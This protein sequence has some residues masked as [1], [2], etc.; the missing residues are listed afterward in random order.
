M[1]DDA[2]AA[3]LARD[4]AH[5]RRALATDASFLVQAPAGSGKTELLIQRYLALLAGVEAPQRVVAMT[6]TRKAASEMRERI[7]TA[8]QMARDGA[9]VTMPHEATTRQL[10]SAV[11]AQADRLGWSLLDHPAQLAIYT[12]DALCATLASQ[13]PIMSRLGPSVRVVERPQALYTLAARAT[14]AAAEAQD[15]HWGRLLATLDNDAA[16]VVDLV[17]SMLA[18]REQ[19]LAHLVDQ[20]PP[21]LRTELESALQAEIEAE[22]GAARARAPA[23]LMVRIA[24]CAQRAADELMAED[25]DAALAAALAQCAAHGGLPPA[26]HAALGHWCAVANWLLT[27]DGAP[28]QRHTRREGVRPPSAGGGTQRDEA[29]AMLAALASAP[30]FVVALDLV[31]TLPPVTI[32]DATWDT[33]LALLHILPRAVAQFRLVCARQGAT[34]FTELALAAVAAL[35]AVDAPSELLLRVDLAIEHLLIDEFQDTSKLQFDLIDLLTAG[36]T[37]GDGRTLFAVGDPMQSIYRFR[38]AEVRLFLQAIDEGRIGSVAVEFLDLARNFRSQGA[39]VGWVNRVF[40]AILGARNEPWRGAVAFAAAAVPDDATPALPPTLDVATSRE[41]EAACTV[42]RVREALAEGSSDI[43]ILVRTRGDLASILPALR[44]E[45]IGFAAVELDALAARQA[46]QDVMALAHALIQPADRLAA[47]AVLRAPWCGI[48]LADLLVASAHLDH[49]LPGLLAALPTIEGLSTDGRQRLA[50]LATVIAPAFAEHG[51]G[52]LADRVRGT[53][54]ALGGPA[55]L[56]E[57]IDFTAVEDSFAVLRDHARGG[58]VDDWDAVRDELAARF[59]TSADEATSTVKIMTLFKAKGLEFDTVVIPGLARAARNDV[60][61]LLRWRTRPRGLLLAPRGRRG[62]PDPIYDYLGS[63]AGTEADHEVGRMLYVGVTR[64]RRRLH[65]VATATIEIDADAG[66]PRWRTPRRGTALRKLWEGVVDALPA[67]PEAPSETRSEPAGAPPLVRLAADFVVPRLPEAIPPA[68]SRAARA[69]GP[70]FE[71]ARAEAA[72][73][74][75][76]AHRHLARRAT[77]PGWARDAAARE[78]LAP[79]VRAELAGEGVAAHAL[80]HAVADVL[81]VLAAVNDDPRGRWLF[82]P[83]HTDAHS[84]WALAGLDGGAIV[85][86]VLDRTFIADGQRWIVD[87]KTGRH[88]GADAEAFLAQEVTRYEAQLTRYARLVHALEARP[89]RLALYYP[90]VPGGWRE[91][92]YVPPSATVPLP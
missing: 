3:R 37:P 64:A 79:H 84:E 92:A 59:V 86:V 90:L 14:L 51:T 31:R 71:W 22:L 42:A 83:T 30:E 66:T 43:A 27:R 50:R 74:G 39:L 80:D 49:G 33:V 34:D 11:L 67:A 35:G 28:R 32:A 91:W 2:N 21:A 12:I 45:G 54:L 29:H 57:P 89:I 23:E 73:I 4:A 5:R 25:G 72:I 20:D 47:L 76:V 48:L 61:P 55:T 40:P 65:L 16:V 6:F 8:L 69:P 18:R 24:Q 70:D 26:E 44:A 53:W 41:E 87:F 13:A 17:A 56:A 77:D 82:D 7:V 19:W 36:W 38:N 81:A 62:G 60:P 78:A 46:V 52:L 68:R 75:T 9:P 10:A 63:L 15:P 58:D 88:E 1:T 85:H